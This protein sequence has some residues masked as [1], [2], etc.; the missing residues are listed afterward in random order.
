MV[1]FYFSYYCSHKSH[2]VPKYALLQYLLQ[3][4]LTRIVQLQTT[5]LTVSIIYEVFI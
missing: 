2:Q 5:S 4:S 3:L 1:V